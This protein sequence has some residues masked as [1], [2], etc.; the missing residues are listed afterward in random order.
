MCLALLCMSLILY[1]TVRRKTKTS[2]LS[3]W[4]HVKQLSIGWQSVTIIANTG[5][6]RS[7]DAMHGVFLEI[8]IHEPGHAK[9]CSFAI[10][11]VCGKVFVFASAGVW[12]C[13]SVY[14]IWTIWIFRLIE[15]PDKT[16]GCEERETSFIC[17]EKYPHQELLRL[18]SVERLRS[19]YPSRSFWN[20]RFPICDRAIHVRTRY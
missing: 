20:Q 13:F 7:V 9:N 6:K 11:N 14:N 15:R 16:E 5:I 19:R 18:A 17:F 12:E 4:I 1:V 10:T 3:L 8:N 2:L